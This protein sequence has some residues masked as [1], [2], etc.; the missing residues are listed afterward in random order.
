MQKFI[1]KPGTIEPDQEKDRYADITGQDAR[2]MSRVL[3]L[4]IGA[5]VSMTNG[6]GVDYSGEVVNMDKERVRVKIL[7]EKPSEAESRLDLTICSAMLKDKKMDGI[8]KELTQLGVSKWV[9]F[10]SQ[11]SVPSPA[12][13][14]LS[15][16]HERWQ[17]IAKESLKQ[18]RR[19]C[20]VEIPFPL[21]FDQVMELAKVYDHCIAFWENADAPLV[22]DSGADEK[23]AD[24]SAI[25]LVGPEGGFTG[26][27]IQSA[28]QAGFKAYSLG[29]RILRAETA[30]LTAAALVQY[31]IGDLGGG[32]GD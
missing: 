15:R 9:P 12:A 10:F 18:C 25:V 4:K 13:T 29:P 23:G 17:S 31:L 24:K 28:G 19:S 6:K 22:F 16:R 11:R 26:D 32:G 2:H 30:A 14:K 20:E 27:E 3:R 5:V 7:E 21:S 1:I 8:I